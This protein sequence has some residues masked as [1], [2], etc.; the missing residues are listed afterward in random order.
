MLVKS[1]N[2]IVR[3]KINHLGNIRVVTQTG[4]MRMYA[5]HN[6]IE[7]RDNRVKLPSVKCLSVR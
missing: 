6:N 3:S 1:T 2:G 4:K 7:Q 5:C